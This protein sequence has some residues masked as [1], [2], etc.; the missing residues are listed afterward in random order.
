MQENQAAETAE[1]LQRK[2]FNRLVL[3]TLVIVLAIPALLALSDLMS[4]PSGFLP[5]LMQYIALLL[6]LVLWVLGNIFTLIM[7]AVKKV[8]R[9]TKLLIAQSVVSGLILLGALLFWM[10]AKH[11]RHALDLRW[12][13]RDAV[14]TGDLY[15][16]NQALK[17]CDVY[18]NDDYDYRDWLALSVAVSAPDIFKQLAKDKRFHQLPWVGLN[19]PKVNFSYACEGYYVGDA[20]MLQIATLQDS[21]AMLQLII[22]HATQD[23]KNAGLWYAVRANRIETAKWLMEQGADPNIKDALGITHDGHSLLDAAIEGYGVETLDWLLKQGYKANGPTAVGETERLKH[24][25]LHTLV[26]AAH[27]ELNHRGHLDKTLKMQA[28]LLNAGA[29]IN[30]AKPHEYSPPKTALQELLDGNVYDDS[31]YVV[32][33]LVKHGLAPKNLTDA[34]HQ[35]LTLFLNTNT[36]KVLT[37]RSEPDE[38]CAEAQL[39]RRMQSAISY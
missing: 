2:K 33:Q 35:K 34:E 22:P 13:V 31:A 17:A 37:D 14:V 10:D 19:A 36:D 29:D 4:K 9:P 8:Q 11:D 12:A 7:F 24:T 20:D 21:P 27:Q 28:L 5:H 3:V 6:L 32:Q 39:K 30:I 1:V 15:Q 26:Y 16:F 18:C 38:N 25:P 23:E